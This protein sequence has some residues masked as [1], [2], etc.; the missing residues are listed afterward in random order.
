MATRVQRMHGSGAD[1]G[2]AEAASLPGGVVRSI[3]VGLPRQAGSPRAADAMDRRWTSGIW[4]EAVQGPVWCGRTNLEGDGQ[5][6]LRVH[7]GLEKAVLAYSGAHYPHWRTEL[8][9]PGMGPGGFGENLTVEGLTERDVCIGDT[10]AIGGAVLQLSQPRGPCWKLARRWR[11]PELAAL[12]QRSGRTGWYYRVL[13]EGE[14][15]PGQRIALVERPHPEWTV[16]RANTVMYDLRDDVAA[17]LSLAALPLLALSWRRTLGRRGRE[18]VERNDRSRLVGP[19]D[20]K[21]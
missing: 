3:Q 18:G 10:V 20:E 16:A 7:G 17:T 11:M 4:K 14:I 15:A 8:A 5:A 6:D 13:V 2:M 12:T 1:P 19:N 9:L 21:E